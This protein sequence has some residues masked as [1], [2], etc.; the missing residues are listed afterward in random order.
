MG[1]GLAMAMPNPE[2]FVMAE[3]AAIHASRA[4]MVLLSPALTALN[5][6]REPGISPLQHLQIE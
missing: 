2:L 6:E 1:F 3:V 5:S 4:H